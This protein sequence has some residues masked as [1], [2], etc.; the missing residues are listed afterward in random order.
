MNEEKVKVNPV[1][2]VGLGLLKLFKKIGV[3]FVNNPSVFAKYFIS[4]VALMHLVLSSIQITTI[5]VLENEICGVAMF[6][7]IL[8]GLVCLFN[9]IRLKQFTIKK[10]IF[11][12]VMLLVCIGTGLW[13]VSIYFERLNNQQVLDHSVV[14]KGI[15]FSFIIVGCYLLGLVQTIRAYFIAKK[16]Q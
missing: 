3:S 15:V 16:V 11:P 13:L 8:F 10:M 4:A 12:I 14:V 2:K 6:L 9:A 7:F 5:T 1:K